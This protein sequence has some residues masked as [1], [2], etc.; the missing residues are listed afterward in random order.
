LAKYRDLLKQREELEKQIAAA[1]QQEVSTALEQVHKLIADYQLTPQQI[2]P[3]KSAKP[4]RKAGPFSPKYR[5][6]ISGKTWNGMGREPLWIKGHPREH[7]LA[8]K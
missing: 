7:F 1:R 8:E 5:D 4:G 2:F 3:R 6:P